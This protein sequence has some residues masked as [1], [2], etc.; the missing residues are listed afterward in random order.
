MLTDE[1]GP[2]RF[3]E[4]ISHQHKSEWIKVMQEEMKCLNENHT[5]DLVKLPKGKRALKNKWF[6]RLKIE[7]NS[8]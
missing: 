8:Q 6:N 2:E 4:V 1:R 5:Y 7:N 3:E